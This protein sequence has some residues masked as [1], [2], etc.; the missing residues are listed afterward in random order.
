MISFRMRFGGVVEHI[1]SLPYDEI[2]RVSIIESTEA[3][4][5]HQDLRRDS[6][7][8]DPSSY[9]CFLLTDNKFWLAPALES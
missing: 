7:S 3:V 1:K 5:P 2:L 9:R 8:V 4:A 6:V